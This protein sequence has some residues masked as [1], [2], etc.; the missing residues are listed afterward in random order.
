MI[1]MNEDS[2]EVMDISTQE[3]QDSLKLYDR[4]NITLEEDTHTYVVGGNRGYTSVTT[5]FSNHFEKFNA[6]KI[7]DRMLPKHQKEGSKYYGMTKEDIKVLW[8]ENRVDASD[9]GTKLHSDIEEFYNGEEIYNDTVEYGYFLEFERQRDKKLISFIPEMKVYN[10][11]I[12]IAGTIDMLFY[13]IEDGERYYHIYDWKRSKHKITKT[14]NYGK[15]ANTECIKHIP[16]TN[17]YKYVLQLNMYAYILHSKY[18]MNVRSLNIVVL[19][20]DHDSYIHQEIE[21]LSEI[22]DLTALLQ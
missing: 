9:K 8:E 15:Y 6:D 1:E 19:H 18:N 13:E 20:P 2:Q 5:W 10:E 7:I 4:D 21:F 3:S 12:M 22:M 11:D 16:N 17:Y 14:R